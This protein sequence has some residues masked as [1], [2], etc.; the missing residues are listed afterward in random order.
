MPINSKG[1]KI[2]ASMKKQYGEKKAEKVFYSS[3]N[4]GRMKGVEGKKK[5]SP[6]K[7]RKYSRVYA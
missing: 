2:M 4:S 1:K 6:L 3:I 7:G 5:V